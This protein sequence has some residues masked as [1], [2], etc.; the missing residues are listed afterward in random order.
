MPT[1]PSSMHRMAG[2]LA[3]GFLT[4]SAPA[5]ADGPLDDGARF[6]LSGVVKGSSSG[7]TP[8]RRGA[9]SFGGPTGPTISNRVGVTTGKVGGWATL[10]FSRSGAHIDGENITARTVD[11]GLGSRYLFREPGKAKPAPYIYGQGVLKRAAADTDNADLNAAIQ[12]FSRYSLGAGFGGEV[13]IHKGLSLSAEVG[14]NHDVLS[15]DENDTRFMT[16]RTAVESGFA[17][18]VYF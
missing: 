17:A 18:N 12:D 13:A 10:G 15:Y 11:I 4:T 16:I 3:L 9:G 5:L 2:A 14:L 7:L 1:L 6:H 8:S